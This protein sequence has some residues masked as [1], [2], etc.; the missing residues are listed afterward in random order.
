M[1]RLTSQAPYTGLGFDEKI[2]NTGVLSAN[3]WHHIAA[4]N[5]KVKEGYIS[6]D[7]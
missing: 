5:D 4:V 6:M 1:L 3:L 7:P 2:T